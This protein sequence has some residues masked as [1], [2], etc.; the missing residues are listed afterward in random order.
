M[1]LFVAVVSFLF[2]SEGAIARSVG[3][4]GGPSSSGGEDFEEG[5]VGPS[6]EGGAGGGGGSRGYSQPAAPS[7]G[8]GSP[9]S[10]GS[11]KG[12]SGGSSV[13]AATPASKPSYSQGHTRPGSGYGV[14]SPYGGAGA[15]GAH[16]GGYASSGG[17]TGG[18]AYQAPVSAPS[19]TYGGGSGYGEG[20]DGSVSHGGGYGGAKGGGGYG[21]D[22]SHGWEPYSF[23]YSADDAEGSHSHSAQGDAQGRVSGQY[24]IQLADGR[25]RTVKY[26]ADEHGYRADIVTNELGTESKNPADVTIQSSAPTGEEAAQQYGSAGGSSGSYGADHTGYGGRPEAKPQSLSHS[27]PYSDSGYGQ[28]APAGY[29]QGHHQQSSYPTNQ[30]HAPSP[31]YDDGG[32]SDSSAHGAHYGAPGESGAET[33]RRRNRPSYG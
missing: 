9:F 20:H 32:H 18:G 23:S 24:T 10:Y 11:G 14:N 30:H 26:T 29:S 2:L 3:Y 33:P 27:K 6:Y 12:Y 8:G 16:H 13:P 7:Y 15:P 25:S 31:S 28:P 5:A 4:S 17:S 1:R 22:G 19:P 21:D